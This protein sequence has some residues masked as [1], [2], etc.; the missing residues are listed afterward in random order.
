MNREEL[1]ASFVILLDN[2]QK[3]KK[4]SYWWRIYLLMVTFL[5]GVFFFY[6]LS[7][8]EWFGAAFSVLVVSANLGM[9]FILTSEV[10]VWSTYEKQYQEAIEIVD[11]R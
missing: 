7:I 1:R 4:R 6:A 5:A 2:V 9:S 11:A 3:R 8:Q 10:K